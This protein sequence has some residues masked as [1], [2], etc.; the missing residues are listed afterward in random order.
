MAK[1]VADSGTA[2]QNQAGFLHDTSPLKG[3]SQL[4]D[5]GTGGQPSLGNFP[6]WINNCTNDTWESCPYTR[7]SRTGK[8]VGQPVAEVGWFGF[9]IDTGFEVDMTATRRTNLFR[10]RGV[11]DIEFPVL[12]VGLDDLSESTVRAY[13]EIQH[14]FRVV[15][16]GT[17]KPSFGEGILTLAIL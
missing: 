10:I 4:H 16:N 14:G 7:T 9:E 15:G 12:S 2:W 5:E 3:I 13:A 11:E 6:L 1:P 8:R 17:F